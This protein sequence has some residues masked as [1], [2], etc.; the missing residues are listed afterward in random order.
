MKT[1]TPHASFAQSLALWNRFAADHTAMLLA[2]SEVIGRRTAQMAAHGLA[3]DAGERREMRQM[4]SEKQSAAF[5]GS[6]AAWQEGMRLAQ[7]NWA[8]A[9]GLAMRSGAAFAPAAFVPFVTSFTPAA[10]FTSAGRASSRNAAH[11]FASVTRQWMAP[12]DTSLT[13]MD[14]AL[15]PVRTRVAANRKRLST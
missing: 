3:P 11:A 9:M 14:A 1:R 5:E 12:L 6:V 7:A 8:N 4:V 13:I 15:K 10:A 2:A